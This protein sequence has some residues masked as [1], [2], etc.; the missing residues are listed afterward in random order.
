MM[1]F[2]PAE[3]GGF[4][5]AFVRICGRM[6]I[7]LMCSVVSVCS[8]SSGCVVLNGFGNSVDCPVMGVS[9][10]SA[11]IHIDTTNTQT[12]TQTQTNK[13]THPDMIMPDITDTFHPNDRSC[14]IFQCGVMGEYGCWY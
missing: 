13:C 2:Q 11:K 7:V 8:T 10:H 3:G 6:M 1:P 4:V 5:C 14:A 12:L 9:A